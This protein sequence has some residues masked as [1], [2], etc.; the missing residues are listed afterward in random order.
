MANPSASSGEDSARRYMTAESAMYGTIEVATSSRLRRGRDLA[1]GASV[2]R[3]VRSIDDVMG[4]RRLLF[5][6]A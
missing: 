3:Q 4:I 5:S 1:C 6:G 2:S